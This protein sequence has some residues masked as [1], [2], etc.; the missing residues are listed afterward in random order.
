MNYTKK[1][2]QVSKEAARSKF[3]RMQSGAGQF[4]QATFEYLF[5]TW[6]WGKD[7][8]PDEGGSYPYNPEL[9]EDYAIYVVTTYHPIEQ[10]DKMYKTN[11]KNH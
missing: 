4:G 2:P 1:Y 5:S 11:C 9:C 10:L 7:F 6:W 3:R 8:E